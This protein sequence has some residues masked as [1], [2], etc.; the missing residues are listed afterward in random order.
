MFGEDK[1]VLNQAEPQL[2]K[3]AFGQIKAIQDHAV[4]VLDEPFVSK[5]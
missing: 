1:L 3:R 4:I 5:A 2:V